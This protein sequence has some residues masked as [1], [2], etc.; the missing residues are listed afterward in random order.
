MAR[1]QGARTEELG[2]EESGCWSQNL[3]I[4]GAGIG[5]QG[6]TAYEAGSKYGSRSERSET[7]GAP[8]RI[9]SGLEYDLRIPLF[10][11]LISSA[12]VGEFWA[13]LVNKWIVHQSQWVGD[14]RADNTRTP[15]S[16]SG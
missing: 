11:D 8:R 15:R 4:G 16:V 1:E 5:K 14:V 12:K 6:Y 7:R 13:L 3:E 9:S 10:G 2:A